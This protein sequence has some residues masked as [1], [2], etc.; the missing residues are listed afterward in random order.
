MGSDLLETLG[1]I[2]GIGGGGNYPLL[3]LIAAL[4]G[5]LGAISIYRVTAT[6]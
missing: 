6:R 1:Q 5:V 3:F 4:F 2:L